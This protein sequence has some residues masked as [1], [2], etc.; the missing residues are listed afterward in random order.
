MGKSGEFSTGGYT[1]SF[2]G[3]G[4][5]Y[6]KHRW[7]FLYLETGKQRQCCSSSSLSR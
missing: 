1:A 6:R 3:L 5:K 2:R 4:V 7:A